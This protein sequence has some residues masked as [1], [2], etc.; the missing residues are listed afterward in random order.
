MVVLT[1]DDDST[2]LDYYRRALTNPGVRFE[3]TSDPIQGLELVRQLAPELVFLDLSLPQMRGM[4]ALR[5]ICGQDKRAH[6]VVVS[7][8]QSVELAVEVIQA[9]AANYICKPVSPE[10]LRSIVEEVKEIFEE[11]ARAMRLENE[12]DKHSNLEGLIGRSVRMHEMFD[13]MRR[14]APHFRTALILGETG[15]GKDLVARALHNM[16]PRRDRPFTVCNCAAVVETLFESEL[17]GHRKGA[18]TGAHEDR[19]GLFESAD[20]GIVFLDEVGELTLG[21]QSKLLRV[22]QNQEIQRVGSTQSLRV[23]VLMIAATSRELTEDA[24][25]GRFRPD[26]LYRLDMIEIRVPPLRERREDIPLLWRHFLDKYNQHYNKEIRGLSQ[27]AQDLLL[28]Y[29]WPGNVRE[30]EN[31]MG[32]ACMLA[33]G[34]FLDVGDFAVVSARIGKAAGTFPSSLEQAERIA[35][36]RALEE[37]PNKTQAARVLGVSRPKLYR[38]MQK[39]GLEA[40]KEK[41]D[42]ESV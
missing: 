18:F 34:S 7:S 25:K 3:F 11:R 35:L 31:V 40:E 32:R 8:H 16:S 27:K 15:T 5:R 26:L 22:I 41:A 38:L 2:V 13:L 39:H 30:L 23:D 19:K 37:H 33:Q 42:Q 17:F 10:T 21:V 4:E 6:V 28:N 20:G 14:V 1:I 12:L 36:V 9:G 24:K 29:R